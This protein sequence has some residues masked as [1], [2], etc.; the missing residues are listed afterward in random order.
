MI[1][2]ETVMFT[3]LHQTNLEEKVSAVSE[4]N[5]NR[6]SHV[7]ILCA[8]TVT[9]TLKTATQFVVQDTPA[10]MRYRYTKFG[11]KRFSSSEDITQTNIHW[12]FEHS[13]WTL[14]MN[15]T[16]QYFHRTFCLMMIYPHTKFGCKR[17]NSSKGIA[18]TVRFWLHK[19]SLWPW[20]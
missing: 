17:I 8:P 5:H 13:V 11:Y 12:K 19:P 14:T 2:T 7:Y 3:F 10:M 4:D 9:L 1:I 6:N 16:I 20:L 18:E 15:T